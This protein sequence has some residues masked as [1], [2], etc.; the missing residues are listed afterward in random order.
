MFE[1]ISEATKFLQSG[2]TEAHVN[3]ALVRGSRLHMWRR[4]QARISASK[5]GPLKTIRN[6]RHNG[7]VE[8][9]EWAGGWFDPEEFDPVTASKSMRKGLP[10]WRG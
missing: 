3:A 2:R 1:T 7:R 9:F 5:I 8:T 4:W 10:D 6:K